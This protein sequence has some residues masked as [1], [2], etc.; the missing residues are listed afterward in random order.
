M[1]WNFYANIRMLF[2]PILIL[3][4]IDMRTIAFFKSML[5]LIALFVTITFGFCQ[6]PKDFTFWKFSSGAYCNAP[7][8]RDSVIFCGSMDKNFYAINSKTGTEIWRF[9]ADYIITSTAA[10]NNNLVC[11]ESGNKLYGLNANTGVLLWSFVASVKT[12]ATGQST[13][14]H[15]SSPIIYHDIAYYG[16]ELGNL[17]GVNTITGKLVFQ[18]TIKASYTKASNYNIRTKPAIQ[19]SVI[20]FGDYGANVYAISLK[21]SSE[22]WIHKMTSPKWDGSLVSEVVIRDS[23][24]Y[25]GGYNNQFSPLDIKTGNSRWKFTDENTFLPST[26]VFYNENVILGTTISSNKIHS[27]HLSDGKVNWSTNVKGIFFV[28]PVI[29]NDSILAINSTDPFSDNIGV[30]YFINCKNGKILNQVFLPNATESYPIVKGDTL[31]LGIND[32]MYAINYKPY[33]AGNYSSYIEFNDSTDNIVINKDQ[34]LN[35]I[36]SIL[37]KSNFCDSLT[38]VYTLEGSSSKSNI[39]FK[40]LNKTLIKPLQNLTIGFKAPANV[41]T[42][43]LYNINFK[44]YSCHQPEKSLFEKKISISVTNLVSDI[45][46]TTSSNFCIYPNP[47]ESKVTFANNNISASQARLSIYSVNGNLLYYNLFD[48]SNKSLEWD[49]RNMNGIEMETGIYIY[50]ITS[51]N[52]QIKGKLLKK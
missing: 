16:D 50:S 6:I 47:F 51:D 21:D 1:I 2:C 37:N 7:L 22:K 27:L 26:P 19:D 49:G 32:G 30:L 43:G 23:S 29:F 25:I 20:Y 48:K 38:V 31:F 11:F 41:L 17:N 46:A 5:T 12:P 52:I 24:V 39:A 40:V 45:G 33:L 10:I 18:Y 14:Y 28:K 36:Y 8:V 34:Q 15:H 3:K 44:V 42:P 4:N 13:D 9:K 35:K